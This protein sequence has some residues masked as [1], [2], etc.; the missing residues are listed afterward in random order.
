MAPSR[1]RLDICR[2][3]GNRHSHGKHRSL[4]RLA[5]DRDIATHHARELAREG[6]AESR[7]AVASR[8]ERIRL[9]EFLEQFRL[10]FDGQA[11]A[12]ICDGKL[13]PVAS[14]VT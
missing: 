7:S 2:V 3:R 1:R 11:N 6:K 13:D 8:G 14:T 10:L 9:G 12:S 4:A 5:R